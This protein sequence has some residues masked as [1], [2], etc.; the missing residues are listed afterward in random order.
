IVIPWLIVVFSLVTFWRDFQA[1]NWGNAIFATFNAVLTLWAIFA[2][3]G[4]KN[5]IVDVAI[6][7]VNWVLIDKA[8]KSQAGEKDR[9]YGRSITSGARQVHDKTQTNW[10][11]ILYFGDR[12]I[13]RD[14]RRQ[15]ELRR[16][17]Q[18]H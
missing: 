8:P 18:S 5:S 15:G 11:A 7:A 4:V 16:R 17:R 10:K 2:Y 3:I 13:A 1:E 6:G 9:K 14:V 12:R